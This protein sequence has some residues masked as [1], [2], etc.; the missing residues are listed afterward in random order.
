MCEHLSDGI[1]TIQA[2]LQTPHKQ[3]RRGK[4]LTEAVS[5]VKVLGGGG[6][7]PRRRGPGFMLIHY[8]IK[9][10]DGDKDQHVSK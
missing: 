8:S 5:V 6:S 9:L 1:V 2:I 7:V 4:M 10:H 3:W